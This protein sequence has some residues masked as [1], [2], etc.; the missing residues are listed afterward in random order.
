MP[1]G[2]SRLQAMARTAAGAAL[3]IAGLAGLTRGWAGEIVAPV[4]HEHRLWIDRSAP[5]DLIPET[6]LSPRGLG[7]ARARRPV[8]DY[9]QALCELAADDR[10]AAPPGKP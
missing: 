2:V 6:D 8:E 5:L 4:S 9:D 10:P 3:L 7:D 1:G